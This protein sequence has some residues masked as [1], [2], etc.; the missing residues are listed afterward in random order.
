[1]KQ[2]HVNDYTWVPARVSP[3]LSEQIDSLARSIGVRRHQIISA[4]LKA[5]LS[6]APYQVALEKVMTEKA[7]TNLFMLASG[8]FFLISKSTCANNHLHYIVLD[9]HDNYIL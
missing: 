2:Q 7:S 6:L 8:K 1:M 3:E 5:G 9:D 4:S